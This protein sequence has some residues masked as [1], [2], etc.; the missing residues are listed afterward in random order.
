MTGASVQTPTALVTGASRNIGRAIALRLARLGYD[1]I[2]HVGRDLAAGAETAAGVEALGR[3]ARV[4][5]ADLSDPAQCRS[6]V[7]TAEATFSRLDALV[8]NAALRPESPFEDITLEEWRRVMGLALE[9]PFLVSQAAVGPLSRSPH[10]SIVHIGGLTGH[11]GAAHRAHVITAKAGLVGLA[12]AMAH[13]L[14]PRGITVNCVVPGL[15]E[16]ARTGGAPAHHAK[17]ANLMGHRGTADDVAEAVAYFC[18]PSNRYVT[19]Q[20]L[21]VNGGAYLA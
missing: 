13:D 12:K 2:V 19:G 16:T 8:N 7:E 15:I 17:A 21:H 4:I 1:I 11:T 3:R 18:A 9:A 5:A 10:A 20:S 14:A 6:L